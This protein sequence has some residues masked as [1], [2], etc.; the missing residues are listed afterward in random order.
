MRATSQMASCPIPP[1]PLGRDLGHNSRHLR[2][3]RCDGASRRGYG[4]PANESVGL[5]VAVVVERKCC[6]R[7]AYRCGGPALALD[8]TRVP[9]PRWS[10]AHMRR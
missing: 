2:H 7:F 10:G 4:R 6:C 5:S 1:S 8:F 3:K 9:L